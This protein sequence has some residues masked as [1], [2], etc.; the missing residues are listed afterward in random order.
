MTFTGTCVRL[1]V[2][3][4]LFLSALVASVPTLVQAAPD[5]APR[6]WVVNFSPDSCEVLLP[7]V[8]T[9]NGLLV[10][11]RPHATSTGVKVIAA[12]FGKVGSEALVTS[13][14][15]SGAVSRTMARYGDT[16]DGKYG[17]IETALDL[18]DLEKA[19]ADGRL[20][21]R[22]SAVGD[23]SVD[24]AGLDGAM[25]AA[26][27][28]T[29]DLAARWGA[30]RTWTVNPDPINGLL[31]LFRANDF[32]SAMIASRKQGLARGLLG[33]DAEGKV[34]SC[35]PVGVEGD[36]AFGDVTCAIFSKR[37]RF[38][39]ARDANGTPVPSFFLSP[40]IRW[41]LSG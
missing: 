28:C 18:R 12:P 7:R 41:A 6:K 11:L 35:K 8:G 9:D 10:M 3:R 33:I 23:I 16:P 21:V 5:A 26:G 27:K 37:A 1:R 38:R 15:S 31:G 19:A 40:P 34:V 14:D 39:A 30:P 25:K 36:P 24:T 13:A 22:G 4:Y 29:D 20:T 2:M 17:L 32:P